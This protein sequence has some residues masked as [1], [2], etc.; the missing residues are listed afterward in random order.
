MTTARDWAM[1]AVAA[2]VVFFVGGVLIGLVVALSSESPR[3]SF[4]G[5]LTAVLSVGVLTSGLA[6]FSV[7]VLGVVWIVC[8]RAVQSVR[9]VIEVSKGS[10]GR[11]SCMASMQSSAGLCDPAG[12]VTEEDAFEHGAHVCLLVGVEVAGGFE[13]EGE[14][15]VGAAFVVVKDD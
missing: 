1:H 4:V 3:P 10:R 8:A 9:R 5:D 15:F 13:G 6:A 2:G 11:R 12:L 7:L 14:V